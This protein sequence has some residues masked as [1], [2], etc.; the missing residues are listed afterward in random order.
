MQA[1]TIY[2]TPAC[3]Y[4]KKAKAFFKEHNVSY[5]EKDVTTD[6]QAR[7]E[8]IKKSGQMGVPV[9]EVDGKLVLGF[10]EDALRTAL[11]ITS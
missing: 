7:D 1:A 9:I 2:T 8:M 10:D 5:S 4:C 6:L 11:N 3:G